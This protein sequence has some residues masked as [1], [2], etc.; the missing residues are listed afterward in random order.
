[1]GRVPRVILRASISFP[2]P[3]DVVTG[4]K[5]S[6]LAVLAAEMLCVIDN[7]NI[8]L[9]EEILFVEYRDDRGLKLG[10]RMSCHNLGWREGREV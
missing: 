2:I 4:Y 3:L 6:L 10:T 1:M 7:V 8:V 5:I 9:F